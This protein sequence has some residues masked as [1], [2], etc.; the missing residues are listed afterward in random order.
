LRN[1]R[2]YLGLT[3]LEL[4]VDPANLGHVPEEGVDMPAEPRWTNTS[5]LQLVGSDDPLD[6]ISAVSRHVMRRAADA[7]LTGPP[8]DPFALAE[9]LGLSLRG[10][11]DVAD[12]RIV[13]GESGVRTTPNA[14]LRDLL[15]TSEHLVVEYNPTQPRGR[16]RYSVAHE[17]AHAF[18]PDVADVVRQRTGSGAVPGIGGNDAWQLELLCNIAASELLMPIDAVAG[19]VDIDPDI[20][21][22]MAQRQRFEVSTEALMR[23][24]ASA[25]SRPLS[26]FATVRT[27]D[28]PGARLR[29]E[30]VVGS[31][32]WAGP[33]RRGM[34]LD[35][36]GTLGECT[37]VGQTARGKET[38]GGETL[39]VQAVGIPAYPGG[40]F[41]RVI[42]LAE[43][44]DAPKASRPGIAYVTSDVTRVHDAPPVIIAHVVNNSA[45]GWGR[46]GV[47]RSIAARFP[48]VASA[49][50]YWTIADSSNLSLGEVH[51]VNASSTHRIRVASMVAQRGYGVSGTA[52]ISYEAL[53]DCLEKVAEDATRDGASVHLPRIGT[54][55]AGGRWDLIEVELDRLLVQRGIPVT[56]HTLPS[57][58]L[59]GRQQSNARFGTQNK[60]GEE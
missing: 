15:P 56:V 35:A 42:G 58:S 1:S 40:L 45:H 60:Q 49:Y 47:A 13:L 20:D 29:V 33:L 19:L 51:I 11:A 50:R 25:T 21:F 38:L 46:R 32:R 57:K 14:P 48:D 9:M 24:L 3:D 28:A 16:L 23:R 27:R 41:P 34:L 6:K 2:R 55:Q 44:L 30:Y 18:F 52:R 53:A 54:G 59:S 5:V 22:I 17:I 39:S 7:G 43:P 26:V 36:T 12:A 4:S 10:H 37:A 8:F 31:H